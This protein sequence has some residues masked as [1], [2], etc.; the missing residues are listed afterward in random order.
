MYNIVVSVVQQDDLIFVYCWADH[1]GKSEF[2]FIT[3]HSYIF[4]LVMRTFRFVE[5]EKKKKTSSWWCYSKSNMSLL[6]S[7]F[8]ELGLPCWSF[9]TLAIT[10]YTV[11]LK[12]EKTGTQGVL[13]SASQTFCKLDFW[14]K[15]M[16]KVTELSIKT[17]LWAG[18]SVGQGLHSCSY[19]LHIWVFQHLPGGGGGVLRSSASLIRT[20]RF[21]I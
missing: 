17:W 18:I 5:D 15:K 21:W 2:T 8:D 10:E 4:F 12:G 14:N 1:C 13:C 6:E 20:L 3:I 7:V 11:N 9:L 19:I 16:L